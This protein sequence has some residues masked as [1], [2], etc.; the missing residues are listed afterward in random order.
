M[1]KF[2]GHVRVMTAQ[3]GA[4]K[5]LNPGQTSEEID[6]QQTYKDAL[7]LATL[8][9]A[10]ETMLLLHAVRL[11]LTHSGYV[12]DLTMDIERLKSALLLLDVE[13]GNG[14]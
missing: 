9:R 5:Q 8:R 10:L 12:V 1:S 4:Y 7:M 3:I 14:S 11:E 13:A 2:H 6:M